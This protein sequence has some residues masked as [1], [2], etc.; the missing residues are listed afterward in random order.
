MDN[1]TAILYPMGD[2]TF[3][4]DYTHAT[5]PLEVGDWVYLKATHSIG[6]ILAVFDARGVQDIRTDAD[7][8]QDGDNLERLTVE[9]FKLDGVTVFSAH[10]PEFPEEFQALAKKALDI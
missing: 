2:L 8:M 9:H 5:N 4:N 1:L 10:V 3:D 7:G 6:K